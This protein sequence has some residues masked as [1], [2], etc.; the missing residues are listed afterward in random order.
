VFL[1]L[2]VQRSFY[3]QPQPLSKTLNQEAQPLTWRAKT[4]KRQRLADR[5]LES[6]K[7]IPNGPKQTACQD[8]EAAHARSHLTG[9]RHRAAASLLR[10]PIL[11]CRPETSSGAT[12]SPP[13]P[14]TLQLNRPPRR[15]QHIPTRHRAPPAAS[16]SAVRP[17]HPLLSKPAL[18]PLLCRRTPAAPAR[19]TA[20]DFARCT[21][22]AQ[23]PPALPRPSWPEIQRRGIS[24]APPLPAP[25][26]S[27]ST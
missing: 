5:F 17:K 1:F 14:G 19:D 25:P 18:P 24:L 16:A 2:R 20:P 11:P 27:K 10:M 4:A 22:P 21:T 3:S 23:I 9:L 6:C 26:R 13:G 15:A 12:T 8:S 7:T